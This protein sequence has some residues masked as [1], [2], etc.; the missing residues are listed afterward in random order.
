MNTGNTLALITGASGGIGLEFA[1]DLAA[2]G[3]HLILVARSE[4]LL[5]ELAESLHDEFGVDVEIYAQDLGLPGAA[6]KLIRTLGARAEQIEI[7][8]NNAGFGINGRF[9]KIPEAQSE[10]MVWLNVNTLTELSRSIA[11]HMV[12]RGKGNIINIASVAAFQPC[13]NFAVYGA[14]KA[15]V[16][17]LSEAMNLEYK[18]TGVSVTA[19]C[20]GATDTKFHEVA[21]TTNVLAMKLMDSA[22]KVARI[23]LKAA[24]QGKSVVVTG[25]LNKGIPLAS[26]LL[27]RQI[28]GR[29]AQILFKR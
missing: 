3:C 21:G 4:H 27:P 29:T 24:L 28:T 8:I 13:P 16:L 2:K 15:Y 26:K 10:G 23:G 5:N 22:A 25:A 19:V 7:L 6:R 1:R 9:D 14:T 18:G 11:P 12:R 17:S 20:P